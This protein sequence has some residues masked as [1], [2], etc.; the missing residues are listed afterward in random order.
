V[1][2]ALAAAS[3]LCAARYVKYQAT[4]PPSS[5]SRNNVPQPMPTHMSAFDFL[6]GAV[7]GGPYCAG[8][9]PP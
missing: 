7:P 9:G 1:A 8:D 6:T 5:D 2:N 3:A 4:A